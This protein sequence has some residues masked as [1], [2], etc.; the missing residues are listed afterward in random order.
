MATRLPFRP[1][2]GLRISWLDFDM[3]LATWTRSTSGVD[4]YVVEYR[5]ESGPWQVS[6]DQVPSTANAGSP[7]VLAS[8]PELIAIGVRMYADVA[9]L[10]ASAT[11]FVERSPPAGPYR[12]RVTASRIHR[13]LVQ[14]AC[15]KRPLRS[16]GSNR[17]GPSRTRFTR[18][19]G[20][21]SGRS[22]WT[23]KVT[24]IAYTARGRT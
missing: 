18:F 4:R 11:G 10:G 1:P 8:T 3:L 12:Y 9:E 7:S 6:S 24:S 5:F 17:A 22:R 14:N 15:T 23:P 20:G 13:R 19:H 2:T 21:S 16:F